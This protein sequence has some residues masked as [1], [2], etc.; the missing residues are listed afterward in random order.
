MTRAGAAVVR[1]SVLALALAG[2][3]RLGFEPVP[4][5]VE[6]LDAPAGR[7]NLAFVTAALYAGDLAGL[8][9]DAICA[10]DAAAA[11]HPGTFVAWSSGASIT[12]LNGS[13][14]WARVDGV[15]VADVPSDFASNGL[16]A[17]LWLDEHGR[18]ANV[19]STRIWTGLAA[20]GSPGSSC[21]QWTSASAVD[22]GIA[23]TVH[24]GPGAFTD[25]GTLTCDTSAHLLCLEV[26]Q[27]TPTRSARAS[28]RVAFVS[29][30]VWAPSGL[31]AADA[32]CASDA[33]QAGLPGSYLAALPTTTQ[34]TT[35][36]FDLTGPP[37]V[38]TDGALVAATAPELFSAS[39]L[40]TFINRRAD[41]RAAHESARW[42]AGNPNV[43]ATAATSC[44]DW[45][46][47]TGTGTPGVIASVEADTVFRGLAASCDVPRQLLC[48]QE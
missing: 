27:V 34:P 41:G 32:V 42:W 23:G 2:C 39:V 12:R 37:W 31:A 4:D 3:G 19:G 21:L 48:L 5:A 28:G 26:G 30:Q 38:R 11:G 35:A 20:D 22:R 13:R 17:P 7:P 47:Q 6:A 25:D 18:P 14:G 9:G 29:S 46:A 1:A 36:R 15:A 43:V 16:L 8:G 10:R 24:G 40:A 44:A 33:R 45:S